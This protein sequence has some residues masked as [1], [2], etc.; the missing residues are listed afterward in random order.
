M[1]LVEKKTF[2]IFRDLKE[3]LRKVKRSNLEL[4]AFSSSGIDPS[5]LS[6]LLLVF[7]LCAK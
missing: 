7:A 3:P 4:F 5:S 6:L 2:G 1:E